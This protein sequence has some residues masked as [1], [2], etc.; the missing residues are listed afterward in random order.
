MVAIF[1]AKEKELISTAFRSH[2]LLGMEHAEVEGFCSTLTSMVHF[3]DKESN[4]FTHF[5]V[6]H[7][8]YFIFF[9]FAD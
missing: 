7:V 4:L 5:P 9:V 1:S 3:F 2:Q 8:K 6:F